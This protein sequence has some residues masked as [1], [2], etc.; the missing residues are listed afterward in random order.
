MYARFV[1]PLL[2]TIL[3]VW[4][5]GSASNNRVYMYHVFHWLAKKIT[6]KKKCVTPTIK[7]TYDQKSET[8]LLA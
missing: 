8:F 1:Q 5:I 4:E 7:M 6:K 3:C 2:A